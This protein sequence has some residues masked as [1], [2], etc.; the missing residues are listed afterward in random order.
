MAG[1][2]APRV[3]GRFT[4]KGVENIIRRY[5]TEFVSCSMCRSP[6]TVLSRDAAT[7]VWWMECQS[8]N[9]RKTVET[10]KAGYQAQFGKRRAMR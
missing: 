8:C 3:Q 10:I 1:N 2:A 5:I 4:Q 9:A 7:R 6:D